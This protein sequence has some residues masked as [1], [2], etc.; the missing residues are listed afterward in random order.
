MIFDEIFDLIDDAFR[1]ANAVI[2]PELP[3]AAKAAGEGTAARHIGDR[4]AHPERHVDVFFPGEDAPIGANGVEIFDRRRGFGGDDLLP[5]AERKPG[6]CAARGRPTALR[7]C[8]NEVDENLLA[9]P[10]HDDV[11]PRRLGKD[12]LE[13]EGRVD[14]AQDRH[15]VRRYFFGDFERLFRLVDRRRD[16]GRADDIGRQRGDLGFQR[17]IVDMVR[18]R[19][20]E[21]DVVK[22][23]AF[24]RAGQIRRPGRRPIAG[25]LG[26]A[27][28]I[29]RMDQQNARARAGGRRHQ[30]FLRRL[31]VATAPN[32]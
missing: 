8:L 13:H 7:D 30:L 23:G 19:V 1:I 6:D 25:D 3:L 31:R 5:V 21:R 27:R 4:D 17:V 32:V 16:G 14:A 26:A 18:H 10:A 9:L 29:I 2:A 11:D 12:L 24:Q 28:M 22:A 20:D 15:R